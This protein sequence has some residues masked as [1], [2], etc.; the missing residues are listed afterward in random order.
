MSHA[1]RTD[2]EDM[3]IEEKL[4]LFEEKMRDAHV[5]APAIATFRRQYLALAAG[6]TGMLGGDD[7]TPVRS[8]PDYQELDA[9]PEEESRDLLN[10]F[11]VIKLNGGL[12]T[13]MGLER[14]KSLIEVKNGLSFL[15]L[16]ARQIL[17]RRKS[18]GISLPILFMDSYN[19]QSDT[20]AAL[21]RYPDLGSVVPLS[22]L[23]NKVPKILAADL[24]PAEHPL[25]PELGWC[26]PGHGDI[27]TAMKS[28]GVL[29][30]LIRSGIRY[31]F[32]SNADN[33]GAALD[34]AIA[35]H[36]SKNGI[37]F[38]MEVADRTPA[39]KKGGHLAQLRD[40][41]LTL[42]ESAQCP[43]AERDA[44]EDVTVH[45]YFNTNNVWIDLSALDHLLD[46]H[47]GT[48][49]LPLIRNAK[50]LDPRDPTSPQVIQPESAMGAAISLF[51]KSAALRV[52]RSRFA[53]VKTT[54]DL[55]AVRS[56]A[57]AM[58]EDYHIVPSKDIPVVVSLD[59]RYYRVL[60]Q[61]DER[62]P[63]GPP[64]LIQCTEF[65]V[66]GDVVFGAGI[67]VSGAVH[68]HA[69]DVSRLFIP[70]GTQLS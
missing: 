1:P 68:I 57:Y 52:P 8:V 16:I 49:P 56:D 45:R 31:A 63:Y 21:S 46:L 7:I 26:P 9:P 41:R 48:L 4:A 42:R 35:A 60:Q 32:V 30:A 14:A 33:L 37:E 18:Y 53:P 10:R 69:P 62:F 5:A 20:L 36:M 19:T 51:G 38:L 29:D 39:D 12:G 61:L 67:T 59:P 44:F 11:A 64:S 50:T 58:T 3:T 47:G 34:P 43:P 17:H 70:D 27:Y 2:D 40:G 24:T 22:F 54:D 23:Q 13:S 25:A 65:Q 28:T 15:D 6:A 55:V 66:H